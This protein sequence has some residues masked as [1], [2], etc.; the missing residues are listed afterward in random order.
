MDE[1]AWFHGHLGAF[2]EGKTLRLCLRDDI[3]ESLRRLSSMEQSKEVA[4]T[5]VDRPIQI[6]FKIEESM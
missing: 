1:A 3:L 5:L 4:L 2:L 6:F